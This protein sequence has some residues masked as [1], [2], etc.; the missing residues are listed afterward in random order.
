MFPNNPNTPIT[1]GKP[2]KSLTPQVPQSPSDKATK[3]AQGNVQ[4]SLAQRRRSEKQAEHLR[5]DA[6]QKREDAAKLPQQRVDKSDAAHAASRTRAN[7]YTFVPR[8]QNEEVMP[9]KKKYKPVPGVTTFSQKKSDTDTTATTGN[10]Y[11]ANRNIIPYQRG[12]DVTLDRKS[13]V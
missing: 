6:E 11:E 12:N 4:R 5:K 2:A 9:K 13:V 10:A 3:V 1:P 8:G 7:A